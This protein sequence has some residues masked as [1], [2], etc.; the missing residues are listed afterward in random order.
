MISQV[1][2]GAVA[3]ATV[4]TANTTSPSVNTRRRLTLSES[5]P[6][7]ALPAANGRRYPVA[8]HP[9]SEGVADKSRPTDASTTVIML[10]FSTVTIVAA[11]NM[12]SINLSGSRRPP[13][14]RTTR[15]GHPTA[16][17]TQPSGLQTV[18][19]T[20]L[21]TA[22]GRSVRGS[23]T[24]TVQLI[25]DRHCLCRST[26]RTGVPQ[27]LSA[28]IPDGGGPIRCRV[29][30]PRSPSR[31]NTSLFATAVRKGIGAA[32]GIDQSTDSTSAA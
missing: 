27:A 32:C 4:P 7:S 2:V 19:S 3:A 18:H 30:G 31:R 13:P 17:P 29:T 25:C 11:T 10:L 1:T 9:R 28:L 24:G 16:L 26:G 23:S 12:T 14:G 15:G 22:N 20:S 6:A 8:V 5:R 21:A